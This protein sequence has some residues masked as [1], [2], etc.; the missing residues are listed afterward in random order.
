MLLMLCLLIIIY[1]YVQPLLFSY[2]AAVS[3]P[4]KISVLSF[5]MFP[6]GFFM[7][8]PFPTGMRLIGCI[9]HALIPWAWAVNACFSV[10]APILVIMLAISAGFQAVMWVAVIAYMIAVFSLSRLIR[11]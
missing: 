6:L 5:S 8:I 10:L 2:L 11:V 3:L 7:G 9:N 4:V 1:N